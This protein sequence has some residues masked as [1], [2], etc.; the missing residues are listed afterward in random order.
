MDAPPAGVPS[1][2]GGAAAATAAATAATA[3]TAAMGPPKVQVRLLL[4]VHF[5]PRAYY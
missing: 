2:A 5:P 4:L 3:A 1:D